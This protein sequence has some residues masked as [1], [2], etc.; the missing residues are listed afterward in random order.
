MLRIF[1]V[2]LI[3]QLPHLEAL[4]CDPGEYEIS[5]ECCPM[6]SPGT[7]VIKHCRQSSSTT[8][9][10]CV[11]DTYTE[12]PNGLNEC[13][14]CKVCDAGARLMV[15]EKC[16]YTKNT[17]CGCALGDFCR[18]PVGGDC[19]MCIPSIV[20]LPGSMVKISGTEFSDNVCE[21]CPDGT[22]S[23]ANMSHTCQPWTKCEEEGMIEQKAGTATSDAICVKR[24]LS[25][26]VIAVIIILALIAVVAGA[27]SFLWRRKKKKKSKDGRTRKSE[28]RGTCET[29]QRVSKGV[30]LAEFVF[31]TLVFVSPWN[32]PTCNWN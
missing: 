16:T 6:C 20:C 12:H 24:G 17:V 10:P 14:R 1:V 21:V 13:M 22:F 27:A 28:K 31:G 5:G 8:C 18:H 9:M 7:R 32:T 19:E 29:H 26:A 23:A 11:S 2:F 30:R 15:K 3:T 25:P 4:Q